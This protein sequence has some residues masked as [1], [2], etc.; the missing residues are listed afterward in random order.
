MCGIAEAPASHWDGGCRINGG[1]LWG[2]L[3][4]EG[5]LPAKPVPY[6]HEYWVLA[7]TARNL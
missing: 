1:C 6:E 3:W 7:M 2:R 5:V 4:P